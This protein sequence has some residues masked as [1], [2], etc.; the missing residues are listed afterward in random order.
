M[1]YNRSFS[2]GWLMN[3]RAKTVPFASI[4]EQT[5]DWLIPKST[6]HIRWSCIFV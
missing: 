3:V 5:A 1:V 4:T 2:I 6:A